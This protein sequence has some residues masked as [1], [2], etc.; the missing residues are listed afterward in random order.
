[1]FTLKAGRC[2]FLIGER[3]QKFPA[4]FTADTW[5]ESS[6]RVEMIPRGPVRPSD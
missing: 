3:R 2:S 4:C 5:K 1:M 6:T